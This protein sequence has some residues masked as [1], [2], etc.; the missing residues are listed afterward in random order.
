M[1]RTRAPKISATLIALSLTYLTFLIFAGCISSR[2]D[3]TYGPE[4]C[5]PR[6]ETLKQIETGRT[7]EAW[8]LSTLG[9]PTSRTVAD[10]SEVFKYHYTR[11]S[12]NSFA[13]APFL[14]LRDED[15]DYTSLYFELKDGTVS[16]FWKED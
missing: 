5:P 16:K 10:G 13:I 14:H 9:E 1:N 15:T 7:T 6:K 2:S 8:L 11:K 3:V 4:G 12:D